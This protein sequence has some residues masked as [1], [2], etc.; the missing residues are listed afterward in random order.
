[1]KKVGWFGDV[2]CVRS[3]HVEVIKRIM[4]MDA[5]KRKT[6]WSGLREGEAGKK[7]VHGQVQG[8]G[9]GNADGRRE[10]CFK[11]E[12]TEWEKHRRGK[13]V[14]MV[15]ISWRELV[16]ISAAPAFSFG[17][18]QIEP[19]LLHVMEWPRM[20]LNTLWPC[21]QTPA[22]LIVLHLAKITFFN[23]YNSWDQGSHHL[24]WNNPSWKVKIILC[25]EVWL[26]DFK[27]L[28]TLW[29][30]DSRHTDW[31]CGEYLQWWSKVWRE[32]RTYLCCHHLA[33]FCFNT[34]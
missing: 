26:W 33:V 32:K 3:W 7:G 5:Q 9:A 12:Q 15:Q 23:T 18:H 1:M 28:K 10:C 29:K 16:M 14:K 4:S 2:S 31:K 30:L 8:W 34:F 25:H 13:S 27:E 22:I 21:G 11:V 24:P 6:G 20:E 17:R 19:D